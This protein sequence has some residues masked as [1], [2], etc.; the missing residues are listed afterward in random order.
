MEGLGWKSAAHIHSGSEARA[1]LVQRSDV[2]AF[3]A[4]AGSYLLIVALQLIAQVILGLANWPLIGS[5]E[6]PCDS[7]LFALLPRISVF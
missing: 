5:W 3:G 6:S 2:L 4:A 1:G 7:F